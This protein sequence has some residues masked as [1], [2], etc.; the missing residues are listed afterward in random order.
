[1]NTWYHS[2]KI[3]TRLV[4]TGNLELTTPAHLGN[5]EPS[6]LVDMVLQ[7]DVVDGRPLLPGSSLAGAL[8]AYLQSL[9][10]GYRVSEVKDSNAL[11]QRLFGGTKGDAEGN[12]SPLIVDDAFATQP[13]SEN[14]DGVRIGGKQ[15]T[16]TEIRDGVCIDGKTRTAL[17]KF[18]Y[19]LELL[20]ARTIFPLRF[21]LLLPAEDAAIKEA[22][23]LAL[24]GLEQ[25][26]IAIGARRSRGFG[27]CRVA[28]W[29]WM[30]YDLRDPEALV[31]WLRADLDQAPAVEPQPISSLLPPP[32]VVDR[33]EQARLE[34]HFTLSSPLLIRAEL[35]LYDKQGKVSQGADQPD[36]IHLVDLHGQPVLPGTSL[37]GV[38]RARAE[39]ILRCFHSDDQVAKRLQDLFGWMPDSQQEKPC[40]SR[41]I[42]EETHIKATKTLVQNRVSIDR[43]TGGAYDTALFSEAPCVA[44]EVTTVIT[45][46]NPKE[47]EVGLLLLL[48]KDLWT[49][50]LPL[51]GSASVG[52][53]R[54]RGQ[55]ATL[56]WKQK[57]QKEWRLQST[58]EQALTV[59]GDRAELE[60]LVALVAQKGEGHAA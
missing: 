53:G 2:R 19:D 33:R 35:P 10:F 27:R 37:A 6:D 7:R 25:G 8:R 11:A 15:S 60:R 48:L 56:Q 36:V 20:P 38:L 41:L 30:S 4:V 52:R 16:L 34:A 43:F 51:G 1:M 46:I 9:D 39:R 12:Q 24:Q 44:G 23:V 13:F 17:P 32:N 57:E 58:P 40:A 22:F 45:I 50:D 28:G 59:E 55:Q 3:C 49:G 14:R 42:V 26:A 29:Q 18:K 5:G 21:E 47:Y 54:L 31:R